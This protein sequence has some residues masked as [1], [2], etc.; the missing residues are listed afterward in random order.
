MHKKPSSS[1]IK[2]LICAKVFYFAAVYSASINRISVRDQKSRWGSCSKKGNLNFNFRIIFLP[3][4]LFDY[5]VVHEICHL[6]EFSHSRK[7][8]GLVEKQIPD[9]KEIRKKLR[10]Y[11]I[12]RSNIIECRGS[13]SN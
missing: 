1:K 9:Y 11:K 4:L 6:K 3:G 12:T 8:W 13:E 5:V 10:N 7:F 2:E